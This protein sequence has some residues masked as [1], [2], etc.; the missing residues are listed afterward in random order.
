MRKN[1]L[2]FLLLLPLCLQAKNTMSLDKQIQSQSGPVF[3]EKR[4]WIIRKIT[5]KGKLRTK[6]KYALKILNIKEGQSVTN[7]SVHELKEKLEF[8][9]KKDQYFYD[10]EAIFKPEPPYLDLELKVM[11]KWSLFPIPILSYSDSRWYY[12]LGVMEGNF[13]GTKNQVG[14]I[15]LYKDNY[16][17]FNGIVNIHK[18][19]IEDLGLFTTVFSAKKKKY[20]YDENFET[21]GAYKETGVGY[22]ANFR[23]ELKPFKIWLR[24]TLVKREYGEPTPPGPVPG[25]GW[26]SLLDLSLILKSWTNLEDYENGHWFRF[27]LARDISW[28]GADFART[29]FNWSFS[30]AIDVF[31]NHNLLIDH[32]GI[33]SHGI[34]D[35]LVFEIGNSTTGWNPAILGYRAGQFAARHFMFNRL[36]YRI[37]L[38]SFSLFNLSAV[39]FTEHMTFTNN[40]RVSE[41]K[42]IFNLGV[43]VR[44]YLRRLLL[45]AVVLYVV[46]AEDNRNFD[47]G[48]TV[49]AGF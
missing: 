7:I 16:L 40:E 18:L 2:L 38:F 13:L 17:S 49:G 4:D 29:F 47:F 23:Y 41:L 1:L 35:Q 34:P 19:F 11:E 33:I 15:L 12:G 10:V 21:I 43:S 22:M 37:P 39:A 24:H 31:R 20:F 6:T 48:V 26:E 30:F 45:P 9:A 14:G 46:Y 27:T 3:S 28:L 8:Q 25:N 32:C 42:H 36:E 5:F 44:M